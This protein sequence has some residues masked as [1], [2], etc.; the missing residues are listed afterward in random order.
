MRRMPESPR[1][2]AQLDRIEARL[3]SIDGKLNVLARAFGGPALKARWDALEAKA[4]V[5]L[6]RRTFRRRRCGCFV[7]SD[8]E[9]SC[10][11]ARA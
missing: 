6:S 7:G 11:K 3:V 2:R 10:A 8:H 9:A 5:P 4:G 1:T